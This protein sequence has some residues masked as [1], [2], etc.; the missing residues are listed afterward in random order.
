[1]YAFEFKT[2]IKNGM[3]EI[4]EKFRK[5]LKNTVKVIL[6]TEYIT[7]TQPDVIEELLESPLK[8]TD[9]RPYKREEVYERG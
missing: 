8:I 2:K 6:L 1:M 5:Q 9:F 4:P 3:I 7:D